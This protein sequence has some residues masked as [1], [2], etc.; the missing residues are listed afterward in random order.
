MSWTTDN[1]RLRVWLPADPDRP[2]ASGKSLNLS[3]PQFPYLK[4]TR[5][6]VYFMGSGENS[7]NQCMLFTHQHGSWCVVTTWSFLKILR[8][9]E[10]V[11]V[12]TACYVLGEKK[13]KPTE[14]LFLEGI[15]LCGE[16][17]APITMTIDCLLS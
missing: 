4:N 2:V 13:S 15:H 16:R 5:N 1:P 12:C 11:L 3:E 17:I 10:S 9:P 14:D 8:L 6:E 7:M